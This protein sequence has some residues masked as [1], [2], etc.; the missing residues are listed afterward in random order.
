[1]RSHDDVTTSTLNRPCRPY[2]FGLLL[3][4]GAVVGFNDV[5]ESPSHGYDISKDG[6]VVKIRY[7]RGAREAIATIV[8]VVSICT[9]NI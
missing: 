2:L 4:Y 7:S 8:K 5:D 3:G 1:M 6:T 9:S